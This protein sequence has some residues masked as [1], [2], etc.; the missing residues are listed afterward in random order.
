ML[1]EDA[2]LILSCFACSWKGDWTGLLKLRGGKLLF[3]MG[4][5][6]FVDE[7]LKFISSRS[8]VIDK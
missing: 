3:Q 8:Q 1:S 4:S 6:D 2:S 5:Q 7:V